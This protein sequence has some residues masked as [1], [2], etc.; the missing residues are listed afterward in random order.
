MMCNTKYRNLRKCHNIVCAIL[1]HF[2][3]VY[4]RKGEQVVLSKDNKTS[5]E[6]AAKSFQVHITVSFDPDN[7]YKLW[8]QY[9]QLLH[10]H[11]IIAS[12]K[13]QYRPTLHLSTMFCWHTCNA[14]IYT[15]NETN[16]GIFVCGVC[17]DLF[18]NSEMLYNRILVN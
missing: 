2:Y 7:V 17:S 3:A 14:T 8:W 16:Q 18:Y 10:G 15:S 6:W 1:F 4:K 5:D 9:L 11:F 12:K 13:F